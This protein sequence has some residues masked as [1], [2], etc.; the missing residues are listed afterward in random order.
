MKS[1]FHMQNAILAA[2]QEN[3][4][5]KYFLLF[6]KWNRIELQNGQAFDVKIQPVNDNE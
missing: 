5:K 4:D 6:D 3:R 2:L 1:I